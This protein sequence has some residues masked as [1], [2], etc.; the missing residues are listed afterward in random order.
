MTWRVEPGETYAHI[1]EDDDVVIAMF[2]GSSAV[3]NAQMVCLL[4]ADLDQSAYDLGVAVGARE[5]KRKQ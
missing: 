3:I 5:A 2:F 4:V 1:V